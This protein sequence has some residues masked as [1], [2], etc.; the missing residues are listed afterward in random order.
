MYATRHHSRFNA[1]LVAFSSIYQLHMCIVLRKR[2]YRQTP[3]TLFLEE[4]KKFSI[5]FQRKIIEEKLALPWLCLWLLLVMEKLMWRFVWVYISEN[6]NHM[7]Q[8]CMERLSYKLVYHHNKWLY[9][10]NFFL[11]FN[12]VCSLVMS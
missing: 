9:L 3:T 1:M 4:T 7:C 6:L 5:F 10:Y 12:N 11:L 2:N 8:T